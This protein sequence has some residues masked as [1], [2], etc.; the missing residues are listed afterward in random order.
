MLREKD[1]FDVNDVEIA[2]IEPNGKLT[3]F[4]KPHKSTI[5]AEDLGI[6]KASKILLILLL[7]KVT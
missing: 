3:A 5:T 7:L 6:K 2:L 1:I 4:K